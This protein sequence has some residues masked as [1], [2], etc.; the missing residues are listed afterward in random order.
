[1][2]SS[3]FYNA[4]KLRLGID[5]GGSGSRYA[6]YAPASGGRE[7]C[8]FEGPPL[9]LKSLGAEA[10]AERIISIINAELESDDIEALGFVSA[11]IAGGSGLAGKELTTRLQKHFKDS[12]I[13]VCSDAAA[14]FAAQHHPPENYEG[15]ALLLC[16]TGSVI[17]HYEQRQLMFRGGYGPASVEYCSGRQLGRDFL[18]YVSRLYDAGRFRDQRF[19][20][21]KAFSEAGCAPRSRAG[22]MD[23]FYHS[24]KEPAAFGPLCLQLAEAGE[25]GCKAIIES[26]LMSFQQLCA[27]MRTRSSPLRRIALYG[28]LFKNEYFRSHLEETIRELFPGA[29]IFHATRD[30]ARHL[31]QYP[32]LPGLV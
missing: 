9:Q 4:Y 27:D 30:V 10:A 17:M 5:G 19:S 29:Y 16:G 15:A 13:R 18:S 14:S 2:H 1:M 24:G 23:L 12:C 8:R 22:M 7:V 32:E 6:L 3:T 28:G 25:P 20:W 31:S 26:H 11:G 21:H